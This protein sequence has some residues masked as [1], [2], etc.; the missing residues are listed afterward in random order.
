MVKNIQDSKSIYALNQDDSIS[1][2]KLFNAATEEIKKSSISEQ[3][4][5]LLAIQK[6]FLN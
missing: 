1:S 2:W 5:K 4:S 6:L 3:P